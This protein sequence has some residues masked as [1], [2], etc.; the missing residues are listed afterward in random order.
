M[1]IERLPKAYRKATQSLS[2]G[3]LKPIQRVPK[4]Y[5]KAIKRL[6]KGYQTFP[7][8]SVK[9]VER[10]GG[11]ADWWVGLSRLVFP[12][13]SL[14]SEMLTDED[15][16]LYDT[17]LYPPF[18][19]F[20]SHARVSL[21][22]DLSGLRVDG[23]G[24]DDEHEVRRERLSRAYRKSIESVSKGY[25]KRI[26]TLSSAHESLAESIKN[27]RIADT[28]IHTKVIANVVTHTGVGYRGCSAHQLNSTWL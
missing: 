8:I 11:L 12:K 17:S 13:V 4:A 26:E 7:L 18:A 9:L 27:V 20:F 14:P 2:K 19:W 23:R 3:Y 21:T 25:Q 15:N 10:G 5:Q 16:S 6:S 28:Y 1:C 24:P 22:L